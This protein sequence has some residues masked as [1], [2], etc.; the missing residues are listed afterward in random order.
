M[1]TYPNQP[2]NLPLILGDTLF[3]STI[4]N[5]ISGLVGYVN[6]LF[7]GGF[8]HDNIN[9]DF[10]DLYLLDFHQAQVRNGGHSQFIH[11]SHENLD[12][13]LSG[14]IR[15]AQTIGLPELADILSKCAKWCRDNPEAAKHQNG[16]PIRALELDALDQ[17]VC[18]LTFDPADLDTLLSG[19]PERMAADL[20]YKLTIPENAHTLTE[21]F[22]ALVMNRASTTSP[23][24]SA[25]NPLQINFN[26]LV[27]PFQAGPQES[28]GLSVKLQLTTGQ[29]ET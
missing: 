28:N 5:P 24:E 19:V 4:Y 29:T 23:E 11:N 13:N 10:A 3:D 16:F 9:Q 25:V 21:Q 14:A 1:S 20:K 2:K 15:G 8:S 22:I 27:L 12:T 6:A 7:Q 18:N 26:A 17:E